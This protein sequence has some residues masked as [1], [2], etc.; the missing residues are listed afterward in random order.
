MTEAI[1]GAIDQ[2]CILLMVHIGTIKKIKSAFDKILLFF[3]FSFNFYQAVMPV[4]LM[5]EKKF[6]LCCHQ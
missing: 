2:G 6:T 4:F 1:Y 5:K 3:S